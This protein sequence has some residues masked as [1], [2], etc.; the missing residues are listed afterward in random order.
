MSAIQRAAD[1]GFKNVVIE[2][3]AWNVIE[4][5]RNQGYALHWSI[6]SVVE[7]ILHFAKG[8]DNVKFSFV[9]REGNKA[10]HL[11]AR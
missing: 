2:G 1:A 6:K 11:L 4:P 3:D 10:A 5:L 7:D 8:F 9:F